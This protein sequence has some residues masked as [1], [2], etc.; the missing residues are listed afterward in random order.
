MTMKVLII[1][2]AFTGDVVLA[3][4]II[5]KLKLTYEDCTIDFL[6]RKGNETLLLD[7]P[8]VNRVLVFDKGK[9]K[10]RNL[11]HIIRTV[12]AESYD[13]VI[14]VQRFLTTGLVTGLSGA[15][16]KIGFRQNPLSFLFTYS[17]KHKI[18]RNAPLIHEVNRN[19]SLIE[20]IADTEF[21]KPKLYPSKSDYQEVL[22]TDEYVCIAPA[23]VWYTKQFPVNKWCELINQMPKKYQVHLLGSSSDFELCEEI[24]RKTDPNR[25]E[26]RAGK[27]TF[28]QSAALIENAKMTFTNDSAP[29]HFASAMDA[30]VTAIYCSTIPAFGFGPLSS[31]SHTI[32][33]DQKLD[34]RPCGLHGRNK[35]PKQHFKCSDISVESIL[36]SVNLE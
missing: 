13:Y 27:L 33:I 32:E 8:L 30:P 11:L 5:E 20:K 29:L 14:N 15:K 21:I 4:P 9:N 3:T 16:V 18:S 24:Q 28:L 19:L 35:C 2:T 10:Y 31:I 1:Q 22:T 6:L 12:R 23:S 17:V 26:I 7:H 34:C 36:K 25:V